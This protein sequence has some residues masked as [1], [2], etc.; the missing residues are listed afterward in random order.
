MHA[1]QMNGANVA[2]RLGGYLDSTDVMGGLVAASDAADCTGTQF[3]AHADLGSV[4]VGQVV[5]STQ[6]PQ[7]NSW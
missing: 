4:T 6:W 5:V 7:R 1:G 2:C 3:D